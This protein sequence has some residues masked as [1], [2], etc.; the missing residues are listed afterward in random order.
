M[1]RNQTRKV[2]LEAL[3][4]YEGSYYEVGEHGVA[5]YPD[6]G[7]GGFGTLEEAKEAARRFLLDCTF[8]KDWQFEAVTYSD[9]D[10]Y[11]DGDRCL[12]ER[13]DAKSEG[14]AEA[15]ED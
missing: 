5:R 9:D 15:D 4:T 7:F 11:G 1:E 2:F 6:D 8:P 12:L 3:D 10:Q 13:F 14:W